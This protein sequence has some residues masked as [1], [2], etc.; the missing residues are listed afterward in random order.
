MWLS[1][2]IFDEDGALGASF[3]CSHSSDDLHMSDALLLGGGP[4]EMGQGGDVVELF[5]PSQHMFDDVGL[6]GLCEPPIPDYRHEQGG[7]DL[8][9]QLAALDQSKLSPGLLFVLSSPC[10]TSPIGFDVVEFSAATLLSKVTSFNSRHDLTSEAMERNIVHILS[11][12]DLPLVNTIATDAD[13]GQE[14]NL[15]RLRSYLKGKLRASEQGLAGVHWLS[16]TQH[17]VGSHTC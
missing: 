14:M 10:L 16:K 3:P 4:L 7:S 2:S 17:S 12:L 11:R 6:T 1:S 5:R 8:Q 13:V 15:D 9:S